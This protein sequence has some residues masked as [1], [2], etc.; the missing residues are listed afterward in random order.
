M[1]AVRP[2]A[3]VR[4]WSRTAGNARA[5]VAEMEAMDGI[6][7]RVSDSPAAAVRGADIICTV[8]GSPVPLVSSEW[9]TD[10]AH[11]NAVGAS[12]PSTRELDT[13]TVVRARVFVDSR[14]AAMAEAGDLLIPMSEE[15]IGTDHIIGEIG[16]VLLGRKTG[17][18][19]GSDITIFESLGLA[20]ED[21]AAARLLADRA[22]GDP[23][24]ARMSLE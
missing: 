7:A 5:L 2:V 15:R 20:I 6:D 16:E 14:A 23:D 10:G 22:A 21:A 13:A 18:V 3:E 4:V 19:A 9:L 12:T 17:R 8:T 1:R 11:I 24:V